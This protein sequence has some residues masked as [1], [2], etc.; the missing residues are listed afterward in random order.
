MLVGIAVV[1]HFLLDGLVHV[2][3][4]PVA[5]PGTWELGLGLW[6]NLPVEMAFEAVMTVAALVL[7]WR[8]A[9]DNRPWRRIGM[10][11]YIVL[12]GAV[13]MVGQAVGTEAPGRT[14]LIAN[15]ITAPV[16]FAAIAWSIDRSG[17][18]VPLRRRSPG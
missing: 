1:S 14:T 5:G 16:I 4:L 7:Y 12:L 2:K 3:G 17:A 13:A 9:R 6:R 8:A 15:W 18:A 10:V 11:V